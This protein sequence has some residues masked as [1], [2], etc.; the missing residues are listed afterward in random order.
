[1]L[2]SALAAPRPPKNTCW[3]NW[4]QEM[5]VN[6]IVASAQASAKASQ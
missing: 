6:S 1:M 4:M 3:R 5:Q 2:P